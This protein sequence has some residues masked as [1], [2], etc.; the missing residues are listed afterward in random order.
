MVHPTFTPI[1]I[2]HMGKDSLFMPNNVAN[3]E[4]IFGISSMMFFF[5]LSILRCNISFTYVINDSIICWCTKTW[6]CS[7]WNEQYVLKIKFQFWL[8]VRTFQ[9]AQ[10]TYWRWAFDRCLIVFIYWY[11]LK[12]PS[13]TYSKEKGNESSAN[14]LTNIGGA[15][16]IYV[17]TNE[18]AY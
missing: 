3:K 4:S 10:Q 1:F 16:T 14:N 17:E 7:T 5:F 2:F 18:D 11:S 13:S 15:Y 6:W 8:Y 9:L 12:L